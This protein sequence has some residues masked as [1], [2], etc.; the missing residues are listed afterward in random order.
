MTTRELP[1]F[2]ASRSRALPLL[3][4]KK[5]R[6]CSQSGQKTGKPKQEASATGTFF[7]DEIFHVIF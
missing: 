2:L 7:T 4:P 1:S 6:D 5:K 3:N